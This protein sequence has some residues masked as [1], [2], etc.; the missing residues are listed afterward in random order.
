MYIESP[1]Y[2]SICYRTN[3]WGFTL[4][5]WFFKNGFRCSFFPYLGKQPGTRRSWSIEE[6]AAVERQLRRFLV[7]NQ[8]A[9]KTDCQQCFAA[10]PEEA[11]TGEPH[12]FPQGKMS[13]KDQN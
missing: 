6:C 1:N 12:R 8:V 9:G 7:M 10:E 3:L 4:N 5:T 2:V 13:V 11:E